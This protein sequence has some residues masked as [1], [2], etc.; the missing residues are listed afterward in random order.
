M[1]GRGDEPVLRRVV[2][3]GGSIAAVTAAASL[4]ADGFDG[5]LTLLS[6][7]VHPP[8]SRVPLSKAVLGGG[9]PAASATL[10]A[11]GDDVVVRLGAPVRG[12]QPGRQRVV[13]ADGEEVP[14]DGLIVATGSH[15]RRLAGPGQV[16]EQV[17]RTVD[18]ATGLAARIGR[19][20][21]VVVAG[22]GFLGMEIASTCADLGLRVTVV[23]R[24]PPL[25]RLLGEWLAEVVVEAA[26]ERGVRL[27]HAP[28]GIELVGRPEVQGVRWAA[29]QVT[30]DVVVSAVG[31]IPNTGWLADSGLI[32]RGGLVVDR[33]CR[34]GPRVYAAGDVTVT[35]LGRG[36]LRRSPHWTSAVRQ[37]R[38]AAAGLLHGVGAIAPRPDPYFWTE[39]FGLDVKI[40]GEIPPGRAPEV[41]AG[42]RAQRSV[43]LQWRDRGRP[44]AAATVNHRLPVVR[45]KALGAHASTV[46]AAPSR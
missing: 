21:S 23:D 7:E 22:A 44:V 27:V 36:V 24:E 6:D 3:V 9:A 12:L 18:D 25:R 43:L 28:G 13:L 15:A 4:R 2:V 32:V 8:Y 20:G 30:A 11:A 10:P 33:G 17:L 26:R 46:P 31:D 38:T 35:D 34:A 14:Y 37:A 45:L 5:A 16:G 39:Q 41:L 1:T 42:D 40:S 19:A 29:G